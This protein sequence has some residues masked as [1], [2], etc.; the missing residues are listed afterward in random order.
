LISR[1]Q[2]DPSLA[3]KIA[4]QAQGYTISLHLLH[5]DNDEFPFEQWFVTWVRAALKPKEMQLQFK[6]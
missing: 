6:I 1:E 2:V 3:S 5:D 4:H